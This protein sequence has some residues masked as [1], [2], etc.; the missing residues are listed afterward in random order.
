MNIRHVLIIVL[1]MAL[2]IS[3]TV[4]ASDGLT[5]YFTINYVTYL[6]PNGQVSNYYIEYSLMLYNNGPY[7][8]PLNVSMRIPQ[9]SSII[10]ISPTA[11]KITNNVVSWVVNLQPYSEEELEVRFKPVYTVLP[12][13]LLNYKVLVNESSVNSTVISGGVGTRINSLI[14]ITNLLPFQIM[15]TITLTKQ[16]GIYYEN[17]VTPTITQNILGYEINSWIFI[18]ENTTS[19]SLGMVIDNMGPWQSVRINPITVQASIDLNESINSITLTI[20]ELNSSINQLRSLTNTIT[21]ASGIAGNYTTQFL[22][23]IALLNQT[24]DVLGSSAYLINSTLLI[25]GLLQAQLIEL[26]LAL[27]AE[28]QVINAESNVLFQLRNSLSPIVNNEQSY[29]TLLNTLKT[30]LQQ[31]AGSISN[32]TIRAEINRTINLINQ[33]ENS[34]IILNQ[35]YTNLGAMQSE[36]SSTQTQLHQAIQGL[37]YAIAAANESE[38][39]IIS[40]SRNLYALHNELINLTN[41]LLNTYLNMATYQTSTLKYLLKVSGY[42][43]N[44]SSIIAEDKIKLLALRALANQYLAYL[45][46]NNSGVDI[47]VDVEETFIINMPSVVNT[48]YLMQLLNETTR[49]TNNNAV[50]H[51]SQGMAININYAIALLSTVIIATSVVLSFRRMR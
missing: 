3:S 21:N 13:A 22:R 37:N 42:E 15:T 28:G 39:L 46:I 38:S 36:L 16:S 26:K 1:I 40:I 45:S 35:V 18:T 6:S 47:N 32:E 41:Q 29:I 33:I 30:N 20:N 43:D 5:G 17:N 34:L 8:V 25:E 31:I 51:G 9:Y 12:I 14:N 44:L 2:M 49:T 27:T 10:Y 7:A 11:T 24:A 48:Q 50:S 4:Y 19:M 23:L